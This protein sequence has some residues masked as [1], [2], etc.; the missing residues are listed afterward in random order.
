MKVKMQRLSTSGEWKRYAAELSV[1]LYF[2]AI[3]WYWVAYLVI[4]P[5]NRQEF[6]LQ[7]FDAS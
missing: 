6:Q 5:L 7:P 4:K 1:R 2:R 3:D